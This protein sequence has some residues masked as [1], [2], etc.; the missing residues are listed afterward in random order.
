MDRLHTYL[1]KELCYLLVRW[2]KSPSDKIFF[3][4]LHYSTNFSIFI[5]EDF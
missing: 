3:H 1:T 4:Y 5:F 2:G